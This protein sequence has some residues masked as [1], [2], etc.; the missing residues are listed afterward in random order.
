MAARVQGA[1]YRQIADQLEVSVSTAFED[2]A[3]ELMAVCTKT[4]GDAEHLRALLMERLEF[5][6]SRPQGRGDEGGPVVLSG[7]ES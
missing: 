2:V 4:R 3:A 6:A 1:N 5:F 7:V